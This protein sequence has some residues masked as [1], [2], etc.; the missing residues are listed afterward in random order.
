MKKLFAVMILLLMFGFVSIGSAQG[1]GL[2]AIAPQVG[3]IMPASPWKTGFS[4][5]AKANMG[6]LAEGIGLYPFAGYWSSKYTWSYYTWS[7]DLTLSNIQIGADAH[8]HLPSVQGL[9]IGGGL[10]LNFMS[11][12]SAIPNIYGTGVTTASASDTKIGIGL[13]AGYEMPIGS[14]LGFV[15]GKYNLISD[16][17]TLELTVGLY[18]NLKK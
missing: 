4:I 7:S 6:D 17:N 10:S 16:F 8:Y 9:Y 14:N 2:K 15:Q 12:E 18:F 11:V 3:L 5:G 13:L 1:L